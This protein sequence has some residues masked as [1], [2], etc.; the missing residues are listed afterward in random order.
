MAESLPLV[1]FAGDKKMLL[2]P[3]LFFTCRE[4]NEGFK[5]INDKIKKEFSASIGN[6]NKQKISTICFAKDGYWL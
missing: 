6:F 4:C 5:R 3:S 2:Q 1:I